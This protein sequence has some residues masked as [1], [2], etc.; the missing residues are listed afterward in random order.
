MIPPEVTRDDYEALV[1]FLYRVPIGLI[2][3]D[4]DG[5]IEMLNPLASQLLMPLATTGILDNVFVVLESTISGLRTR[6]AEFSPSSGVVFEALRVT[7]TAGAAV[8]AF[9]GI[10]KTL[11]IS[12]L[13]L[14]DGK[15]MLAL[16][17]VTVDADRERQRIAEVLH[18]ATHIDALTQMPNRLA[19]RE[20][21]LTLLDAGQLSPER[22]AAVLF[23]NI[24]RFKTI[25]DAFSNAVGDGLLQSMAKRLRGLLRGS[26]LVNAPASGE[27]MAARFGGDEFVVVLDH[28]RHPEDARNVAERM[29]AALTTAHEVGSRSISCSVSIGISLLDRI[30]AS[31]DDVIQNASIAMAEAKRMGGAGYRLYD[32]A[33]RERV[34]RRGEMESEL[35]TALEGGQLLT[36]YQPVISAEG[37][38]TPHLAAVEALVRWR[39]PTRGMIPPL[40]FIGVAEDT[41]LIVPLG[42][43]VLRMACTDF[44]GWKKNYGVAAPCKLAVNISRA[45]LTLPSFAE[46]VREVL[47]TTG[48]RASDLQLELTESLA[49]QDSVVQACLLELKAL[50]VSLALDDFGTGYSSLSCLHLLPVDTVKIDRSFVDSAGTSLHH[51]VLIEATIRVAHSLGMT[52]VAEGVETSE[53]ANILAALQCDKLQGYYFSRAL[54]PEELVTWMTRDKTV[55]ASN[56]N[57]TVEDCL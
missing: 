37:F 55:S 50:G 12:L 11:S 30:D 44:V 51:R 28:L 38:D 8:S 4:E 18:E 40:D 1:S 27:Q 26:D 36:F 32:P 13:K 5:E 41:G 48:M 52:T 14:G 15:Y 6:V 39:H 35:R 17:D 3:F 31:A 45:Q 24:D 53:Q 33:M 19:V 46:Q 54:P 42:H 56:S 43:A 49:A 57:V 29:L 9:P 23:V 20:R 7:V 34:K 2:E 47:V 10:T 21:L 22:N 25:N 16:F